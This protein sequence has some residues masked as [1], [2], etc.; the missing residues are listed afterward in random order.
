MEYIIFFLVIGVL[1]II[2]GKYNSV[3]EKDFRYAFTKEAKYRRCIP[4]FSFFKDEKK[5]LFCA[6][7]VIRK[8]TSKGY[9]AKYY[10]EYLRCDV[11][12]CLVVIDYFM[13]SSHE[14]YQYEDLLLAYNALL[15]IENKMQISSYDEALKAAARKLYYTEKYKEFK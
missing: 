12:A 11:F 13:D 9:A 14:Y 5:Y 10:S 8:V 4:H 6:K 1:F 15:N 2:S 7:D 3:Y